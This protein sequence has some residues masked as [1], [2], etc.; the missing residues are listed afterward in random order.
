MSQNY[1]IQKNWNL[2]L[3]Y[4]KLETLTKPQTL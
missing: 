4:L 1:E 2:Y 3:I